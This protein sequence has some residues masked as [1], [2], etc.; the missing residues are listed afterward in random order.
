[1]TFLKTISNILTIAT[2]YADDTIPQ[3][4]GQI[5][6]TNPIASTDFITLITTVAEW[7]IKAGTAVLAL[8]IVVGAFQM[9]LAAGKPEKFKTG[10]KTII[11]GVIGYVILLLSGGIAFII[12]DIIK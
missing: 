4:S 2:A 6:L 1:M 5:T 11:Y 10:Q 8:V 12:K 7:L 3:P 9:L